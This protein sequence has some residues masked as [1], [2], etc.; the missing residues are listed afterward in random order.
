M[1]FCEFCEISKNIIF[2]EHVWT[3]LFRHPLP[4]AR[5]HTLLAYTP[6]PQVR[7]YGY[8]F[9]KEIWIKIDKNVPPLVYSNLV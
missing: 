1:F 2:T 8:Y 9:L 5:A 7:A 3:S 6:F 4:P